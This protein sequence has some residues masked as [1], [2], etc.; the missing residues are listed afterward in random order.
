MPTDPDHPA[1]PSCTHSESARSSRPRRLPWADLLRRVF[2]DAVLR[3]PGGGRRSVV[4]FVADPPGSPIN[5]GLFLAAS[6][7]RHCSATSV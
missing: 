1:D 3:C 2:A 6:Q 7:G 4:A 5:S